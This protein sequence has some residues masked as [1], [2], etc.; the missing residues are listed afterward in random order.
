MCA[1]ATVVETEVAF[2]F[3]SR[4]FLRALTDN[5]A[6]RLLSSDFPYFRQSEPERLIGVLVEPE[7]RDRWTLLVAGDRVN[8]PIIAG[9]ADRIDLFHYDSDKSYSG[10]AFALH[11]L[12]ASLAEGALV[13]F[14]DVQ[15]NLHFRDWMQATGA[16]HQI[17][18]Y[19]GKWIGTTGGPG[20]LYAV[21]TTSPV[22]DRTV[23]VPSTSSR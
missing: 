16:D 10:R 1:R 7:L 9:A 20:E 12:Q 19:G 23:Q 6:G 22:F 15:D 13:I 17:F 18:E 2:G 4:A 21:P 8:L 3:S 11:A 5:G 14:D